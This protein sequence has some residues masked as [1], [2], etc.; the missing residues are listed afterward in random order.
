[1]TFAENKPRS[2]DLEAL[3]LIGV[4]AGNLAMEF[5]E[6]QSARQVTVKSPHDYVSDADRRVEEH[7]RKCLQDSFP[8][9]P[10]VGEE[11]GGRAGGTYW[12]V[13]PIDGTSNFLSGLPFWAIS[14]GLIENGEP[15][16][17]TVVAPALDISATGSVANGVAVQGLGQSSAPAK[18]VCFAIGRNNDWDLKDR[19]KTE[20][21][22]A[23]EGFNIVGY[24]SCALSLM[25]VA[26][27]RLSGYVE[28]SVSGMW[29]CAGGAALCRSAGATVVLNAQPGGAIDVE[30]RQRLCIA[31]QSHPSQQANWTVSVTRCLHKGL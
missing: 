30:A 17:G 11:F 5:F 27:G 10:I 16:A 23:S 24:G 31:T 19:R 9:I 1:M 2:L 22:V 13:D 20:N 14:I 28:C 21:R 8:S 18:P 26:A 25:L 7:I 15:I 4:N 29:D 12:S 6:T 3:A